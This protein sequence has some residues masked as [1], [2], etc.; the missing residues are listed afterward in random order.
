[1]PFVGSYTWSYHNLLLPNVLYFL[2]FLIIP[3]LLSLTMTLLDIIHIPHLPSLTMI[4]LD[5]IHIPHN[6]SLLPPLGLHLPLLNNLIHLLILPRVLL[7][8]WR[9]AIMSNMKILVIP[10]LGRVTHPSL[11]TTMMD[12]VVIPMTPLFLRVLLVV[13]SCLLTMGHG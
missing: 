10:L 12:N 5:I 4:L 3:H 11:M 8:F 7:L 2:S 6:P 1:M 9:H 13:Y